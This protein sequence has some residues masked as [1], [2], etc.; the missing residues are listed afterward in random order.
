MSAKELADC[1]NAAIK[2]EAGAR[3]AFAVAELELR[4]AKARKNIVFGQPA[5]CL[6]VVPAV[7]EAPAAQKAV[8]DELV[9]RIFS[10]VFAPKLQATKPEMNELGLRTNLSFEYTNR[11]DEEILACAV[12][13]LKIIQQA[14]TERPLA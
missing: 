10:E 4:A 2:E 5:T 3:A 14:L 11:T 9:K 12:R 6:G 1:M 7:I 8:A 13:A